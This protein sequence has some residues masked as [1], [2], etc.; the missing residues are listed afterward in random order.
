MIMFRSD[1]KKRPPPAHKIKYTPSDS[2]SSPSPP[3]SPRPDQA[4]RRSH[5]SSINHP[6]RPGVWITAPYGELGRVEM[7]IS[8]RCIVIGW[9]ELELEALPPLPLPWVARLL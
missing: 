9:M 2:S 8:R 5:W 4:A 3:P 7:Q 6:T 1:S